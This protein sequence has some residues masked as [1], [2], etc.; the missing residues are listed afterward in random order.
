MRIILP[1]LY[2][3]GILPKDNKPFSAFLIMI[4]VVKIGFLIPLTA[5]TA[6]KVFDSPVIKLASHSTVPFKVRLEP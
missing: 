6:A 2:I 5:P 4:C 3:G 1:F